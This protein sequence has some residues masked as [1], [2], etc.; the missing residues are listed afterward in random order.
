ME[1]VVTRDYY[2]NEFDFSLAEGEIVRSEQF[3]AEPDLV[4]NL[5]NLGVLAAPGANQPEAETLE[6]NGAE[7]EEPKSKRGRG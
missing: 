4:A 3:D 7:A 5:V 2:N 1:Y 6:E